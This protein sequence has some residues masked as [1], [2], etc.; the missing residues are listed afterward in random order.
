MDFEKTYIDAQQ[1]LDDSYALGLKILESD[2][3]PDYIVGVWRGGA[4]GHGLHSLVINGA[5]HIETLP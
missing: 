4:F 2:F 3:L 1:L 5:M